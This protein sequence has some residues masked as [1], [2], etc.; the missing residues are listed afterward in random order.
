M[1]FADAVIQP[2]PLTDQVLVAIVQTV[3][4]IAPLIFAHLKLRTELKANTDLT[5]ETKKAVNGRVDDLIA[6]TVAAVD[7]SWKS[8]FDAISDKAAMLEQKLESLSQRLKEDEDA[9]HPS[10]P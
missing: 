6:A 1:L 3:A 7:E 5:K 10:R 4:V 2:S 9:Q 8:K